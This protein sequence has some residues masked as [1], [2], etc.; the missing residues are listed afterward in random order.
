MSTNKRRFDQVSVATTHDPISTTKQELDAPDSLDISLSKKQ[1]PI[2]P[3]QRTLKQ[4]IRDKRALFGMGVLFLFVTIA[5]IGP[6]I[7]QH[8]GDT[9]PSDLAGPIGPHV[10]HQYAHEELSQ[11]D[12]LPSVHYWLGTDSVGRDIL[13]RLMQGLL[14]S[15]TV[16]VTVEIVDISLGLLVGVLAGY[17][18]GWIDF[19]LARF[20]DLMFAF[21]S[22]LFAILL[23]GVFGNSAG[24]FF[25]KVPLFGDPG[26]ARLL[27]VSIALAF[28][29]WPMMARYVRGQ[30]LQIKEAQ[31]IEASQS[32]GTNTTRLI[33]RHII[34]HLL[35]V[36][37]IASTL[38]IAGTITGEAGISLLGLG[39]TDPGSSLG[40]M[41]ADSLE[42]ADSHPW[43]VLVPT[44]VLTMIVLAF[45]FLGDSLR[46]AFDPRSKH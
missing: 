33:I 28:T 1:K 4:L 13:A 24:A 35:S 29:S 9:Y 45:S 36:I 39:V 17:F 8:I 27:V 40:L 32:C 14:I 3:A 46:D 16:A 18:G 2:S 6:T 19:L 7:Y 43:E 38:D 44:L 21:P 20:T 10:Y 42:L 12:Q 15:L 37:F 41:I 22:L 31:F 23:V 25:S 26:N 34:P 11:Q 30:T 5:L